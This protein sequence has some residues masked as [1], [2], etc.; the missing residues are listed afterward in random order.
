MDQNRVAKFQGGRWLADFK[1][2]LL[3][4][5]VSY[6]TSTP[7]RKGGPVPNKDKTT[8]RKIKGSREQLREPWGGSSGTGNAYGGTSVKSVANVPQKKWEEPVRC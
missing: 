3:M 5:G 2:E 4:S 8:L 6:I 1:K 7:R